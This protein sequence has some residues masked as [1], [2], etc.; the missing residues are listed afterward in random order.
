[1][2]A[3]DSTVSSRQASNYFIEEQRVGGRGRIFKIDTEFFK[4]S[5]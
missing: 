2:G 3:S 4:L 1:M 5:G